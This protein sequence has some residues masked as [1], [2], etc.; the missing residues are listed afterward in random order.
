MNKLENLKKNPV[1]FGFG[2]K[3]S[4]LTKSDWTELVQ[5]KTKSSIK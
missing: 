3:S 5:P 1:W 4:K 2:S